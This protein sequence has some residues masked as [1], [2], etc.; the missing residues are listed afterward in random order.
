MVQAGRGSGRLR[1]MWRWSGRGGRPVAL[2]LLVALIAL[3]IW[4]P[5]PVEVLR[6]RVFDAYQRLL[7][8]EL[9]QRVTAV[10]EID[11]RSLR[12]V[13]QWP[14][15]RTVLAE[16]IARVQEAGGAVLGIAAVFPEPDRTSPRA[17]AERTDIEPALRERLAA[18]P[19]N[20]QVMAN[21]ARKYR[22]V[23]GQSGISEPTPRA[24]EFPLEPTPNA[25]IGSDPMPWLVAYPGLLRNTPDLEFAAAGRGVI[26][27]ADEV[28]GVA[29]RVPLV[30]RVGDAMIP[31]FFV[32]MLRV[33]TGQSAYAVQT[34]PTGIE[35]VVIARSP[36]GT[37]RNGQ[38]WVRYGE[39]ADGR[40]VSAVD[41]LQGKLASGALFQRPVLLGFTATGLGDLPATPLGV[42]MPGVEVHAQLL[43]N[44]IAGVGLERPAYALGL[45]LTLT[46]LVGLLLIVLTPALRALW[47]G[48]IFLVLLAAVA[49]GSWL[50]FGESSLLIDASYPAL[51][52]V[53]LFLALAYLGHS[54]EQRDK[55][56][57]RQVFGQYLSPVVVERLAEDPSKLELGGEV[58]ELT[59]LFS[60]IR[61]F[62]GISERFAED[63]QGL[64]ALINRFLTP[65]TQAVMDH[66]GTID[67]YIGDCIMAFWNAP[68]DDP[69]HARNACRGML[70]MQQALRRVN[71]ELAAEGESDL[72]AGQ[73]RT[74]GL[75][76]AAA[77]GEVDPRLARRKLQQ[78]AERGVSRAQ[79]ELAKACRDGVGGPVDA[80]AAARWFLAAAE[81]GHARAQRNI[82]LRY[83]QGDGLAADPRA[84]AFWLQLAADQGLRDA[85]ARLADLQRELDPQILA[86]VQAQALAWRPQVDAAGAIQLEIGL[87]ANT[88]RC[89]VGNLGSQQ[90]FDYSVLGDAVNL[91]SRLEGQSK[92]YGV[93]AIISESVREGAPEFAALE[94]D[95]IA[96]KGRSEPVRIYALLGDEAAAANPH[97][98]R[99]E[100]VHAGFLGAF[101][102]QDWAAARSRIGECRALAP[103]LG[104][105]YE[106]YLGRVAELE[107]RPPGA[108]WQGVLVAKSK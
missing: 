60:D 13:G 10:I 78:A 66:G 22:V 56:Y 70:A 40:Y 19:S 73:G 24:E 83:L 17:L 21:V 44:V 86:A 94:L 6:L 49:G 30:V 69:A 50:A 93:A 35:G 2:A 34:G 51:A 108:D 72:D 48:G 14:W 52:T 26:N 8:V 28:D 89:L 15:P 16:L 105:L 36:V 18:I 62:T 76:K 45:E 5:A 33:A 106:S 47:T 42:R 102:A 97:F 98:Q 46:A 81:H 25:R 82:G 65:L 1:R 57:V 101:R 64:T 55:R 53:A 91:A 90:R 95:L 71:A 3:R 58:R 27:L 104:E 107:R 54:S 96:V 12:E 99:L 61:G 7:P 43:D 85:Q 29:R 20:D 67:K 87:G 31:S 23:L 41:V 11:E 88:G 100:E 74:A 32:E 75:L 84:G 63:P 39:V 38:V 68:L 77:A 103:E 79:Y 80:E 9:P 59:V 92:N 37:D 4:D